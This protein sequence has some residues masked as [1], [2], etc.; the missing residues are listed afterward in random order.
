CRGFPLADRLGRTGARRT[1]YSVLLDTD[2]ALSFSKQH[3]LCFSCRRL[4]I[5]GRRSPRSPLSPRSAA[6]PGLAT[7]DIKPSSHGDA[8]SNWRDVV[9]GVFLTTLFAWWCVTSQSS[10][11]VWR[12]SR[13]GQT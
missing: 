11:R 6:A 10:W 2:A 8:G 12:R 13:F 7:T 1:C 4:Q 3:S 5:N 9:G